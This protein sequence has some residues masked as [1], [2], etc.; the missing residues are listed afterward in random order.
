MNNVKNSFKIS[1]ILLFVIVLM[2]PN[3]FLVTKKQVYPINEN[4]TLAELPDLYTANGL[5][6]IS[7]YCKS[8]EKWY[9]DRFAFRDLMIRTK[10]QINYSLLDY[11]PG[12]YIGKDGYM[13]YR[14]VIE[15]EQIANE[16]LS[17]SSF[18]TIVDEFEKMKEYLYKKNKKVF[19]MIPPQKNTVFPERTLDF[20]V[21]R[22]KENKY[23]IL[24]DMINKSN[25]KDN[26]IDAIPILRDAEK[27]YP[28]YYKT[29]FHWNGYGATQ[30]FTQIVDKI[31]EQEQIAEKIFSEDSYSVYNLENFKGGQLNEF[32][33]LQ[34]ISET[35]VACKKNTPIT[36]Q[37]VNNGEN[38]LEENYAVHY[39][40]SD[41]SAMLGRILLIGDSYTQY[42][43]F[44]DSGLLDC[45]SEVYFVHVSNSENVLEQFI[46]KADYVVIERIESV[47]PYLAEL[48]NLMY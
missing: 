16:N 43:L 30:A 17:Y 42:L 26:F 1:I 47:I 40:N 21:I 39:V 10:N 25:V 29:D 23:M 28:T 2:I 41:S 9:N 15:V 11:T 48:F 27:K 45:F 32:S 12:I 33:I 37:V 20:P 18:Q 31:A 36:M 5:M 8:I 46:D 4:R 13:S 22:P 14:K 35:A 6:E 44:S 3:I 38:N 34:D 19:F 7:E 24:R